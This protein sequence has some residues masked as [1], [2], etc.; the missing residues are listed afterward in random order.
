VR[1]ATSYTRGLDG[2][3]MNKERVDISLEHRRV[4]SIAK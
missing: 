2:N 1:L 4:L 3:I